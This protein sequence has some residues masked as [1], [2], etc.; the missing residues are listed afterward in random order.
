MNSRLPFWGVNSFSASSS[1]V[2][3]TREHSLLTVQ[4]TFGEGI[5]DG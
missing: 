2:L 1:F 4:I 3:D 5:H